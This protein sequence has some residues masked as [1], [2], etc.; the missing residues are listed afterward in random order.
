MK[1]VSLV[2]IEDN[3]YIVV[4]NEAF[5]WELEPEQI[6]SLEFKIKNDPAMKDSFI[7]NIFNHLTT[8]FSEFLGKKVSLKEI[9]DAIEKGFIE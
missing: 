8:C 4:D 3:K 9:N 7:G 6:K 1:T 2:E 5:D